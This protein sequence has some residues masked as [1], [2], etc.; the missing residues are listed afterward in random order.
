GDVHQG[1]DSGDDP[2]GDDFRHPTPAGKNDQRQPRHGRERVHNRE[3]LVRRHTTTIAPEGDTACARNAV[4]AAMAVAPAHTAKVAR[5]AG[6]GAAT[7][8]PFSA[9]VSRMMSSEK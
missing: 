7:D 6:D 4:R 2:R 5:N 9:C 1:K 8:S 3:H